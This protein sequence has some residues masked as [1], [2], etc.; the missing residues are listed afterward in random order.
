M[1]IGIFV[2]NPGSSMDPAVL[3]KRAEELGFESFW[4]GEQVFLHVASTSP[5]PYV[6]VADPFLTLARASAVTTTIK[7]GTGV[8]LVPQHNPLMLAREVATLDRFSG[9][10]FLFGIGTGWP[11]GDAEMM[12]GDFANRWAQTR[13]SVMAMKELWTK[14][15]AEYHGAYYDFPPVRPFPRAAQ[16]PYPPVLLGGRAPDVFKRIVEWGDGWVPGSASVDEIKR[17]RETLNDLA[18]KAGRDPNSIQIVAFG[19]AGRHWDREAVKEF[20]QAGADGVTV[21]L[22]I[23]EENPSLKEMEEVASRLLV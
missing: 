1:D 7:L 6:R 9:G 15:E 16:K 17:G 12:E 22:E 21:W 14:E 20:E 4:I 11:R 2:F 19:G 13:E 23:T 18:Q 10:R 8:C 5:V 3:A